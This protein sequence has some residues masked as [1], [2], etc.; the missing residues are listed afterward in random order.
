MIKK[1]RFSSSS[2]IPLNVLYLCGPA[3]MNVWSKALALTAGCPSNLPKF[4][5]RPGYVRK[6][7][8]YSGAEVI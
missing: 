3:L 1:K 5:S 4:E 2:F 6:L 7:L 8:V